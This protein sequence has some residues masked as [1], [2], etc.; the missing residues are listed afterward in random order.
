MIFSLTI[1]GSFA[2]NRISSAEDVSSKRT[3]MIGDPI[4]Q[5]TLKI[6]DSSY[7]FYHI[8]LRYIGIDKNVVEVRYEFKEDTSEAGPKPKEEAMT[9]I[10][11]L[12]EKEETYIRIHQLPKL[13]Q[14]LTV[15][16]TT[17]VLKVDDR[18]N[19]LVTVEEFRDES[20][21]LD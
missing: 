2:E 7:E 18:H 11:P 1:V 3:L 12:D 5:T 10:F 21:Y 9:L 8:K 6:N 16:A 13:P 4:Y 17:L 15:P 20:K 14:K 19:H